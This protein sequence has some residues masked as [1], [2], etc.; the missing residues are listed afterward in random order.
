[1]VIFAFG[2]KVSNDQ[3]KKKTLKRK[4]AVRARA[5]IMREINRVNEIYLF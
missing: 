1:M 5:R 2:G 3:F 4:V